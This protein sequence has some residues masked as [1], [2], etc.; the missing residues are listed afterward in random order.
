MS[1]ESLT[2][3]Q[4]ECVV[5]LARSQTRKEIAVDLGLSSKTVEYHVAC[6]ARRLGIV[7]GDVAGMTRWA[8]RAG[9]VRA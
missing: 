7:A 8:I 2:Q 3:R 6:A 1:A 5:R 4:L 9:M